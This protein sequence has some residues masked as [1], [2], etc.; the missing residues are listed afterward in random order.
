MKPPSFDTWTI[1]FAVAA[2]QAFFTAIVL[3]RWD[4]GSR[5]GNILLAGI[6]LLFGYTLV[7]YVLYWTRYLAYVPHMIDTSSNFPLLI[8]PMIWLYVRHVYEGKTYD[9]SDAW[10]L[11]PFLCGTALLSL[12]YFNSGADKLAFVQN[13][14]THPI[15]AFWYNCLSWMRVAHLWLYAA[16]LFNYVRQQ[17]PIGQTRRWALVLIG[18]FSGFAMAYASYFVL[19]RMAWFNLEWDYHISASMT[20]FI[21]L[22]AYAGYTQRVVFEG[23]AWNEAPAEEKYKNS[24]LTEEA[25]RTLLEK[26]EQAMREQQLYRKSDLSLDQLAHALNASKHHVSQVIN[27]HTGRNFFDYINWLR[28]QDAQRLLRETDR[29]QMHIIEVAYTVGFNNKVSFNAAFKKVTGQTPSE[30]RKSETTVGLEH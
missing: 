1:V 17:P 10:H 25:R 4:R 8:G 7:E 9:L 20:A 14:K 24:G 5:F 13:Q 2:A 15:P 22:I 6:L 18:F 27:A 21:Y 16:F 3:L 26:L 12:F 29:Q 30:F 11:V 23:F 19:V 28:I